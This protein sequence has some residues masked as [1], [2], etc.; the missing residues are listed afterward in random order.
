MLGCNHREK[1]NFA[2]ENIGNLQRNLSGP[3]SS[4]APNNESTIMAD[5]N[6]MIL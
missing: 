4:V 3:A 1:I 2:R 5:L 6:L